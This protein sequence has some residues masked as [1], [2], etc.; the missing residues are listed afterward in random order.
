MGRKKKSLIDDLFDLLCRAPIWVGPAVAA[1]VFV[2]LR[3]IVPGVMGR[4]T[5]D[6]LAKSFGMTIGMFARGAAPIFACAVLG[7]WALA[8]L[9]KFIN[10][11]MFDRNTDLPA[12]RQ[13]SWS[14]FET[15]ICEAFRRQGYVVEHT[16]STGGDGG[17]DLVIRKAGEITLVQCK[18]WKAWKIGVRPV[19][20]LLGVVT[21]RKADFGIVVTS[22]Q[23]TQEAREF[24]QSNP[25]QLIDGQKLAAMIGNVRNTQRGPADQSTPDI[26]PRPSQANPTPQGKL[27]TE[28]SLRT[29]SRP[30]TRSIPASEVPTLDQ[31]PGGAPQCPLCDQPMVLRTARKGARAGSDF[32]GCPAYPRCKGVRPRT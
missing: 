8:E 7:L 10:R 20:E 21:S 18:Q 9:K 23:F 2:L 19:R 3:F 22:G 27:P 26:Q 13:L 32:W 29:R 4:N 25:L 17:V 14:Q 15:Y 12:I 16:G 30:D 31:Q 11:R 6:P 1:G 28:S 5:D 24:V